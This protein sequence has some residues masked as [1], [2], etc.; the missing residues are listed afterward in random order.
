[1]LIVGSFLLHAK[2]VKLEKANK[3][4]YH[5]SVVEAE[6]IISNVLKFAFNDARYNFIYSTFTYEN[7]RSRGKYIRFL[8]TGKYGPSEENVSC[9]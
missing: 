3:E 8:N 1:M 4:S 7:I 5:Q 2:N 6:R 9:I